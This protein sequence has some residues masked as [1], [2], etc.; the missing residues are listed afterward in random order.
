[1]AATISLPNPTTT[2]VG[3]DNPDITHYYCCDPNLAMCGLDIANH[4]WVDDTNPDTDC[5]LCVYIQDNNLPCPHP[6]CQAGGY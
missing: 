3:D 6:T 5:R 4:P 1:M 2:T